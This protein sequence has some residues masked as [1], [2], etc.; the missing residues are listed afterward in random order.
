MR[1]TGKVQVA[2]A[3]LAISGFFGLI[4]LLI[5]TE[6]PPG[7]RDAMLVLV[8]A[9]AGGYSTVLNY[10]F[11]SSSGSARKDELLAGTQNPRV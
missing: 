1:H 3:I 5:Y 6:P 8:G 7:V 9:V 11:G 10:Y 2:L 4:Y